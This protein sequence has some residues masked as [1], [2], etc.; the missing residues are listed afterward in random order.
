M[1]CSSLARVLLMVTLCSVP[2]A[3][4]QETAKVWLLS[5]GAQVDDDGSAGYGVG[6]D[7]GVTENTWLSL[8]GGLSH[9]P[10]ELANVTTQTLVAGLDQQFGAVGF[11]L[12]LESWG[13]RDEVESFDA[14]GSIYFAGE[15]YRLALRGER[16]DIDIGFT[17]TGFDG[18]Q[19]KRSVSVTA[20]GLG[21]SARL[22]LT[23]RWQLTADAM[24]YDY[25]RDLSVLPRLQV[26]DFLASSALTL[27]NSF[28][29]VEWGAGIEFDLS[30][31]ALSL[32]WRQDRSAVDAGELHSISLAALLPVADRWDLELSFGLSDAEGLDSALFGGVYLFYYGGG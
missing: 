28:I 1:F 8:Y 31:K 30:D 17:I 5:L 11:T 14:S 13:E 16:R 10:D 7:V 32:Q 9:S 25:S 23:E 15:R 22:Q 19:V 6:V 29:D 12:G 24:S 20:D 27:A 3:H 26:F 21:A 2:A 18:R 4:A